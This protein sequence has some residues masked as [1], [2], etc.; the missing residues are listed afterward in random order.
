MQI[1]RITDWKDL[2]GRAEEWNR[3]VERSGASV[4]Q[5]FEWHSAWWKVFGSS[6]ELC[7]LLAESS[8]G[9]VGIAPLLRDGDWLRFLGASNHASDYLDLIVDPS[10]PEAGQALLEWIAGAPWS[11]LDLFNLPETS[12]NLAGLTAFFR[13]RRLGVIEQRITDAPT[14]RL[15][16][17]EADQ[18]ALNKKSL[19][20][21]FNSFSKSGKLEFRVAETLEEIESWLEPFFDQHVGRRA[22]TGDRSLFRDPR[23]REFYREAARRLFPRGWLHFAVVLHDEKPIAFHYGFVFGRKFVW[24]KPSFDAALMKKSPGEVL[25]R[26]LLEHAI[27]RGLEEF[28]FTVGEEAFKYRFANLVRGNHRVRVYRSRIDHGVE[29][30]RQALKRTL[31]GLLARGRRASAKAPAPPS[32]GEPADT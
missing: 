21:H 1:R 14:R 6:G 2:E 27:G 16:D 8:K 18:A 19:K 3:L 9:L 11:K 17:R 12:P 22:A 29:L 32:A 25:L 23:E 28:D 5:T 24:Y 20:R 31:K 7:V 4:F 26:F 13:G 15:G 30:A 10:E